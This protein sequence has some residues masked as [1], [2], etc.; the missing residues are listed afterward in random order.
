MSTIYQFEH[1]PFCIPVVALFKALDVPLKTVQVSNA[2]RARIIKLT[3]GAYYQ[4][5]VLV[6]GKDTVYESTPDSQDVA[7]YVDRKFAKGRLFP[8]HLDGLQSIVIAYIENEVEAV[9]FR[10]VDPKYLASLSNTVERVAIIRHKER[11]FGK[12]CVDLW[13]KEASALRV[14]AEKLLAPFDQTFRHADFLFGPEPVYADFLLFGIIG[15][16]TY[17]NY[18][19]IPPRLK[20]LIKWEK[21]MRA[22]RFA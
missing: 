9:T 5:P 18:N 20:A 15:N 22:F 19:P 7:R 11:K 1:S 10:L 4:V 2:D 16:L 6:N 13:K 21:R 3:K 17:R 14:Q 12:G 8:R